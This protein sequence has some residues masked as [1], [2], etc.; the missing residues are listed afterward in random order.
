MGFSCSAACPSSSGSMWP[1]AAPARAFSMV[2]L[3]GMRSLISSSAGMRGS[4]STPSRPAALLAF[5]N[6]FRC[7][8]LLAD[9][10]PLLRRPAICLG[11][12]AA[13]QHC[14]V[15]LAQT[16]GL[17]EGLDRLLVVDDREGARPVGPP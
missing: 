16:A 15:T 6:S 1:Q 11:A 7:A 17:P 13:H 12:G 2:P 10:S 8:A 5:A 3:W 4:R 14:A 9:R